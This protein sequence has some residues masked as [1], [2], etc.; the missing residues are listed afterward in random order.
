MI[1]T[2]DMDELKRFLLEVIE[3]CYAPPAI[4]LSKRWEGGMLILKPNNETQA[5]EIPI[6]I[7]FK[8]ILT[9]RDSLRVLE[10][11]LNAHSGLDQADRVTFQSYIT[12]A[13]GTLTTFNI[14]FKEDKHKFVGSSSSG[15]ER[16]E[17]GE[18]KQKMTIT[19][20]RKKI[21]LNEY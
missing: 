18:E 12:K 14:L 11:K 15:G 8:K 5:K 7:F 17:D 6:D 19:Q 21:G 16:S 3:E 2:M 13:Y 1:E 4:P 10:Q 20:M 9:V